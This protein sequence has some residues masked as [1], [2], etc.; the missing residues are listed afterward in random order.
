MNGRRRDERLTAELRLRRR[1][2]FVNAYEGGQRVVTRF[3]VAFIV[4][5]S[6]GPLRVGVVASRRVGGAVTRNRAKRLL[7][8]VFRKRKPT[9]DICADMVLVARGP[10]KEASFGDV[11]AAYVKHVGRLLEKIA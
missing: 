7:R 6:Q 5:K 9:R 10:I 8:E 3:F 2:E 1:R 11:D 4:E